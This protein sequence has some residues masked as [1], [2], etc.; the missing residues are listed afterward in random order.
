MA[1]SAERGRRDHSKNVEKLTFDRIYTVKAADEATADETVTDE[2]TTDE[3]AVEDG[4]A[5][6]AATEEEAAEDTAA[7]E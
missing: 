6:D 7:E 5:D 1:G 4:T 2:A 3:T